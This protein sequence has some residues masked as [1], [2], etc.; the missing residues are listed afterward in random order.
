MNVYHERLV[1]KIGK[2]FVQFLSSRFW[3]VCLFFIC[4]FYFILLEISLVRSAHYSAPLTKLNS[5][6]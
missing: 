4:F 2:Y 3:F 1:N 5:A 6:D